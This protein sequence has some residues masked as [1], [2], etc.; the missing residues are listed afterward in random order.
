MR[1]DDAKEEK[2]GKTTDGGGGRLF[3]IPP[4][5]LSILRFV[6]CLWPLKLPTSG[7]AII[8][9]VQMKGHKC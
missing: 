6:P 7:A 1:K 5:H 3:G 8:G 9:T 4:L 2:R